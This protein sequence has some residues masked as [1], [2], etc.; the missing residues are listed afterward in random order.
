MTRTTISR[1]QRLERSTSLARACALE[2]A[3]ELAVRSMSDED[4]EALITLL[5]PGA[6]S[7][8]EAT[9]EE[10]VA[11]EHYQAAVEA[12]AQSITATSRSRGKLP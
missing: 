3:Q 6:P 2:Q 8:A 1:V 5:Q 9:P 12:A 11:A 10:K 4:L 7:L